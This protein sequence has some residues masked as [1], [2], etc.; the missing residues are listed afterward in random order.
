MRGMTGRRPSQCPTRDREGTTAVEFAILVPSFLLLVMSVFAASLD[1]LYQLLLDDSAIYA[2]RQIQ[3]GGPAATSTTNFVQTVCTELGLAAPNCATVLSY[4]VQTNTPPA[5]FARLV[6][7]TMPSSGVLPDALPSSYPAG[8]NVLVQIAYP[9]PF[10][11]PFIGSAFTLTNTN[12]IL[13]TTT[14]RI[15]Q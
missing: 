9:L 14:A 10:K 6:P 5:L 4:N 3:I 8:N 12:S 2:A 1:A 7:L 13:A 11:F 15:E